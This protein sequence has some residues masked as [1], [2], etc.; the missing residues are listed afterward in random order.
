MDGEAL[1]GRRP[2]A[3]CSRPACVS[4][5]PPWRRCCGWWNDRF[6]YRAV[7]S[8]ARMGTSRR[9]A[10]SARRCGPAG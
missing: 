10:A 6:R 4:P 5:A 8:C 9:C 2:A 3:E 1:A 7:Y